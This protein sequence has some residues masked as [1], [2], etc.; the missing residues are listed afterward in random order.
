MLQK[1][2]NSGAKVWRRNG[3][4]MPLHIPKQGRYIFNSPNADGLSYWKAELE[5]LSSLG[6]T[7][8][9][10]ALG[11]L[12]ICKAK[13]GSRD[14]GRAIE[15]CRGPAA[16]GDPY[17]NYVL[18][19]ALVLTNHGTQ[20]VDSMRRAALAGF[21]PAKLDL[22]TLVWNGCDPTGRNRRVAYDLLNHA[23]GHKAA[24]V[25]R[26]RLNRSGEFGWIRQLLGY[27]LA[28]V[29]FIRYALAF[30]MNP[31][32]CKVLVFQPWMTRPHAFDT[33]ASQG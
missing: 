15:L 17:A 12:C 5:R 33:L 13:D 31:L 9:S 27:L 22:V 26:C 2:T 19:W 7:W 21:L 16:A 8:A 1:G 14:P 29:A 28:P 6:S 10:S 24:M 30:W 23:D 32:S 20:A 18:A 11:W 4:A 25:W 3:G